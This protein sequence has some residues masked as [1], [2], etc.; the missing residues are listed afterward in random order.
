MKSEFVIEWELIAQNAG[1]IIILYFKLCKYMYETLLYLTGPT[2]F[3]IPRVKTRAQ[4]GL[5]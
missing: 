5:L 4:L 2:S 1:S 3:F